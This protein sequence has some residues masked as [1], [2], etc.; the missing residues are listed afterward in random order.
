MFDDIV[1]LFASQHIDPF[2]RI[3]LSIFPKT[4]ENVFFSQNNY[5]VNVSD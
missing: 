3:D 1:F 4:H 5:I 2:V